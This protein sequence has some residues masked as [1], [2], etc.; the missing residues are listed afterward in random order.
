MSY[1]TGTK[2]D[3]EAIKAARDKLLGP[4]VR[5][6]HCGGGIH[7]PMPATWDG[8]GKVPPGW[9]GYD[10]PEETAQKDVWRVDPGGPEATAALADSRASRLTVQE[11]T[12]LQNALS[13]A[14]ETVG[15]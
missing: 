15:K 8:T 7:A 14:T 13:V 3:C 4:P 9:T 11:K 1:T 12:L 2:T 5:G 6:I 10:G